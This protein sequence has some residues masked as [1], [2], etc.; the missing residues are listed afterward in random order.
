MA[1][2]GLAMAEDGRSQ[3]DIAAP[4][5]TETI[6]GRLLGCGGGGC[7]LMGSR[8]QQNIHIPPRASCLITAVLLF[9]VE[10][11]SSL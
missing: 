1:G 7:Y 5:Q 10:I 3:V 6:L 2:A 8:C 11:S 9:L 4:S